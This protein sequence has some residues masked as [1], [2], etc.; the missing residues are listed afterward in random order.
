MEPVELLFFELCEQG[1]IEALKKFKH[2]VRTTDDLVRRSSFLKACRGGH[3]HVIEY[4]S[5]LGMVCVGELENDH[6]II[7]ATYG[8]LQLVKYFWEKC[9]PS[10]D[11]FKTALD[12]AIKG[13]HWDVFR[14]MI[15]KKPY[16]AYSCINRDTLV[17]AAKR[18]DLELFEFLE[19]FKRE[20]YNKM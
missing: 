16:N 5:E 9:A 20:Y 19:N 12:G 10:R 13:S 1:N 3:L 15:D 6:I 18:G 4:L 11:V 7:P 14:Y 2:R 17:Y 8:H